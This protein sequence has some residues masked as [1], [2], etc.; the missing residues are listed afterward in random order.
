MLLLALYL[1][2]V[3]TELVTPKSLVTER[4]CSAK[5]SLLWMG[6]LSCMI[7][8]IVSRWFHFSSA[9]LTVIA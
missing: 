3:K 2:I 4:S 1:V 7:S 5:Y 8:R 9:Q 6:S